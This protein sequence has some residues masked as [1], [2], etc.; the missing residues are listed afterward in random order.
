[1]SR[2]QMEMHQKDHFHMNNKFR[3]K[4]WKRK[5]KLVKILQFKRL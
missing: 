1:M 5:I 2:N 4:L 3:N